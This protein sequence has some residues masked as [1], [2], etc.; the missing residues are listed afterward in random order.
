MFELRV[1]DKLQQKRKY[2]SEKKQNDEPKQHQQQFSV[3]QT[4]GKDSHLL[5]KS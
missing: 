1:M 3:K 2:E 4:D 5:K